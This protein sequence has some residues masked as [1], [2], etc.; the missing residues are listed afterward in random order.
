MIGLITKN[1]AIFDY[2]NYVYES[3]NDSVVILDDTGKVTN[4][5]NKAAKEKK[6]NNIQIWKQKEQKKIKY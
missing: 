1:I 5:G 6:Q 3:T 4:I 2:K